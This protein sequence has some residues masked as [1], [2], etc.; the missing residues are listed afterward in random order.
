MRHLRHTPFSSES[1][2]FLRHTT[3]PH[4]LASCS[5]RRHRRIA[6]HLQGHRA[7]TQR[8]MCIFCEDPPPKDD[9]H[10]LSD[11]QTG[12]LPVRSPARACTII[13]GFLGAGKTTLLNHLLNGE[14]GKRFCV[15]QNEFG[16]V[17]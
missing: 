9:P 11:A 8:T 16:S 12:P 10:R 6:S 2:S 7:R 5:R 15:V 17:C 4:D 3:R 1:E 14:H 13:T